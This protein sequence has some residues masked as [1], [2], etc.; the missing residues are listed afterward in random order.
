M[1]LHVGSSAIADK[2]VGLC[3]S[4]CSTYAVNIGMKFHLTLNYCDGAIVLSIVGLVI[5]GESADELPEY[6]F[7]CATLDH[8]DINHFVQ[9]E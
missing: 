9:V 1:T 7:A 8:M 6:V 5:Q 4:Y 3:R 2:I